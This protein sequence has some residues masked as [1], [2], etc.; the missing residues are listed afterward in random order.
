MNRAIKYVFFSATAAELAII[1]TIFW[2]YATDWGDE[3]VLIG[4][5][6]A[7]LFLV[8]YSS[9]RAAGFIGSRSMTVT[10]P[11]KL[12]MSGAFL[13]L[14]GMSF[15]LVLGPHLAGSGVIYVAI[16]QSGLFL[17]ALRTGRRR[18]STSIH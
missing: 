14:A 16:I 5:F 6:L 15:A 11:S 17:L 8:T 12:M 4:V 7:G 18:S 2:I 10:L 9:S 1:F 3:N 13:G